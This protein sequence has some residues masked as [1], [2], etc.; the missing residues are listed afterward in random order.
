MFEYEQ[1]V[2]LIKSEA[3]AA[4]DNALGRAFDWN[5]E[6]SADRILVHPQADPSFM[7]TVLGVVAQ[8][9]PGLKER[10][11]LVRNARPAAASPKRD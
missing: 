7:A 9:A 11:R 4:T 3:D 8:Y 2:R 1:E 6:T 5:P 10:V